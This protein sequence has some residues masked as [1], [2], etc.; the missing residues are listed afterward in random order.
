MIPRVNFLPLVVMVTLLFSACT[1]YTLV[2][3]IPRRIDKAF[4][5]EDPQIQWSRASRG[6]F[7]V[8]TVDGPSL[9]AVRFYKGLI[10]GDTL[11]PVRVNKQKLPLYHK[12]MRA[13]E[14]MEFYVD[15]LIAAERT[16]WREPN[17]TASRIAAENLRPFKLGGHR[18]FRFE[19]RFRAGNGLEYEG[20][21]VGSRI[22]ARLYLISYSGTRQ[23]YF[24]K[25]E[26]TAEK[27]IASIRISA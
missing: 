20:F 10:D 11:L 15:S 24:P 17:L 25:Y 23:Y 9:Q 1:S 3:P 5:V 6:K 21:V 2:K 4:V 26:H 14:I 13:N 8:W 19:I 16:G 12:D 27:L 18:G 22:N 7:E